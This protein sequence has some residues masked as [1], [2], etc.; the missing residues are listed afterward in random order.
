VEW[1]NVA[2]LN[3]REIRAS[4]G[5]LFFFAMPIFLISCMSM[6][7]YLTRVFIVIFMIDFFIR[8]FIN[9]KYSPSMILGRYVVNNQKP[10]YVWAPQKRFA[11]FLWF[12]LSVIM[13]FMMVIFNI[14]WLLNVIIC[15]LCV[16]LLFME[17]A[18]GICVWCKLYNKFSKQEAE[19]C[20]GWVCEIHKKEK[21]QKINYVQII[22]LIAFIILIIVLLNIPYI[23]WE[24]K[25]NNLNKL[26]NNIKEQNIN[27]F[28]KPTDC[29]KNILPWW[30]SCPLR[31]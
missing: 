4:A 31:K 3:E 27:L 29:F 8:V 26:E 13:F 30:T 20:P 12:G 23:K 5:I 24:D 11:W 19:L 28:K 16:L 7:F 2:V 14:F 6:D 25:N 1:Y 9:P 22:S 21:V 15:S 17:S 18:F 10:E